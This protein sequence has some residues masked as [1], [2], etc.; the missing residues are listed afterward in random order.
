M[1]NISLVHKWQSKLNLKGWSFLIDEI[2]PNQVV[3]DNDCPVKDRYFVGIE[4]DKE[5]KIGTIYH[6]RELTEADIIHELLHVKYPEKG[7]AWINTT[8]NIILNNE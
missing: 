3:Y 7:E 2:Q 1:T 4:I 5:N 8:E 6:D